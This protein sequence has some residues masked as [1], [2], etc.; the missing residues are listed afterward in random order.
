MTE[1]YSPGIKL[2]I[3]GSGSAV[4]DPAR[5]NPSA[6]IV[7][8]PDVL[9]FDCGE[10]T[11]VNLVRAGINPLRVSHVFFTHLHWDHIADFN[12]L[13]MTIWNCGKAETLHVHGP[14]GTREMT[15]AFLEAH[16]VDSE[17]VR[18]FVE[19]L[20]VHIVERPA[21]EPRIQH[22]DLRR[23]AVLETNSCRVIA[24]EVKHLNLLGFAHAD[25]GFRIES[26]C[27]SIAISGDTIPCDEMVELAKDVDILVHEAT[28]LEE[29][30]EARAPAW[31]GH[32]G[33]RGAGRI[34]R[35]AGAR[36]LVLTHLGP[37]DSDAAAV[38]MAALYY[39]PRRG[40]QVWSKIIQ[41]AS[42]EFDG[43]VV[44][45]EDGM[46]FEFSDNSAMGRAQ[47]LRATETTEVSQE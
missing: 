36:K 15:Q 25:W 4:P 7:A 9:L 40:P 33:P 35:L 22:H 37:Y 6:A 17:F 2:V 10:R 43:P 18:V 38:E 24:G 27:G 20:P 47:V 3:V 45:A 32:T 29:I 5:G 21:L 44:V 26:D 34:A 1:D 23:G 11:T 28:F 14:P 46:T 19:Q 39:G 13:L 16:H 31:T 30:I 42:A 8:G 41:D 12:Y